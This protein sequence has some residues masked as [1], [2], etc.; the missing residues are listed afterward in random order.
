MQPVD[1]R[2]Q[3]AVPA[4]PSWYAS[5][6]SLAFGRQYC[7]LPHV[8][9]P[10]TTV[11]GEFRTD[12]PAPADAPGR[13][14]QNG[15]MLFCCCA[16]TEPPCLPRSPCSATAPQPTTTPPFQRSAS[17]EQVRPA[18]APCLSRPSRNAVRTWRPWRP[19]L[20][21]GFA[22][23]ALAGPARLSRHRFR[24]CCPC[25]LLVH[26]Q[27]VNG[28]GGRPLCAQL[29][30][31]PPTPSQGHAAQP[32]TFVLPGVYSVWAGVGSSPWPKQAVVAPLN[33]PSLP[34]VVWN[35][36]SGS[37]TGRRQ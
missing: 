35:L 32:S 31:L 5:F 17:A 9:C 26:Q 13:A 23:V 10:R 37:A 21:A 18:E 20:F 25:V 11:A 4:W 16:P 22:S 2:P 24:R 29:G 28:N 34:L 8:A 1:S 12:R 14:P 30:S 15:C 27:P 7:W 6:T 19:W 36:V 33:A 3:P